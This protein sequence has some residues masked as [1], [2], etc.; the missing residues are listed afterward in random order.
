MT[1]TILLALLLTSD[2]SQRPVIQS[3]DHVHRFVPAKPGQQ[4]A[5]GIVTT[6][7]LSSPPNP[8]ALSP[9]DST[10]LPPGAT[11]AVSIDRATGVETYVRAD[12]LPPF[13][14][15]LPP[16]P[17]TEINQPE[18]RYN[19]WNSD[20][21]S[22]TSSSYPWSAQVQILYTDTQGVF[23]LGSGTIVD[24]YHVIT[25]GHCVHEGAGGTWMR[26]TIVVPAWDGDDDAYGQA[27]WSNLTTFTGWTGSNDPDEDIALIR[28][29]R[30]IGL[31]TGWHYLWY[32]VDSD[33]DPADLYNFAGYPDNF[34]CYSGSPN[35]MYYGWGSF[36]TVN[37]TQLIS[38]VNWSCNAAG[39]DGAGVYKI[40]SSNRYVYGVQ[41]SHS[42]FLNWSYVKRT[43]SSE[44][45][46]FTGSFMPT[47]F[48]TTP[49]YR[50][51][52]V[53]VANSDSPITSGT[54]VGSMSYTVGNA[55]Y[56]YNGPTTIDVE[57]YL[58]TNEF[59]TASDT[60]LQTH[61]FSYVFD[62]LTT[63]DVDVPVPPTIPQSIADGT[64]Y[65]GVILYAR[66]GSSA[67]RSSDRSDAVEIVVDHC[68]T[69]YTVFGEGLAGSAGFVPILYGVDG[70]CGAGNHELRVAG[71][72]GGAIGVL[73]VG[74]GVTD[75][76]PVFG[77][78]H[79]YVDMAGNGLTL[80]IRLGGPSGVP[81]AGVLDVSG[82]DVAKH[83]P[84]SLHMQCGFLDTA[85]PNDISLTN[86][87]T[88]Q[89]Q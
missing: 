27:D 48:P 32:G 65:L 14:G 22:I 82:G 68:D 71:G 45:N 46:Y 89:I 3:T 28:M 12:T 85:A 8:S 81:G 50:P 52:S 25:A 44:Y 6:P 86:A 31:L 57:V 51:L 11:M 37:P 4:A 54:T 72:L 67:S 1:A 20:L 73:W 13:T 5:E 10:P 88:M 64:Y 9:G 53:K 62:G 21:V 39:M 74:F 78:G 75:L 23:H 83:A 30:P 17:Y 7:P 43:T 56:Y 33:F 59:I 61:S 84:L 76:F 40:I 35:Q 60:L 26:S 41:R 36:D 77:G 49:D 55:S 29:N 70:G 66:D 38:S 42:T 69:D 47:A 34:S 63:V 79:F 15:Q 16:N 18:P 58:S 80:P 87:L 2:P 24:P 19:V